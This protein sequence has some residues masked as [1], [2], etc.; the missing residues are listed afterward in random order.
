MLAH[1]KIWWWYSHQG[2]GSSGFWLW[3]GIGLGNHKNFC[4][5]KFMKVK[6]HISALPFSSLSYLQ[7]RAEHRL[8][9]NKIVQ[10]IVIDFS[11]CRSE[12]MHSTS[13]P[14]FTNF[15][16]FA[17]FSDN[18]EY[19]KIILESIFIDLFPLVRSSIVKMN[20]LCSSN[21]HTL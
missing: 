21:S 10:S 4:S 11:D 20:L 14:I 17:N 1:L 6:I 12:K 19:L 3:E 2:P 9:E 18:L 8:R 15:Y 13:W 7:F 16:R 5:D